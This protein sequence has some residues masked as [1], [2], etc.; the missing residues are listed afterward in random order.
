MA[1]G[2]SSTTVYNTVAAMQMRADTPGMNSF[3]AAWA[4]LQNMTGPWAV[5][6]YNRGLNVYSLMNGFQQ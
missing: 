2:P 4:A 1:T 3:V 6:A 5:N